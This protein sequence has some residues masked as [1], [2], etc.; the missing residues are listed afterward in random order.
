MR[1]ATC[2]ALLEPFH[3]E[4]IALALDDGSADV[5]CPFDSDSLNTS[6]ATSSLADERTSLRL[7]SF[8]P[9]IATAIS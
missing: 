1:S 4:S 7:L 3:C 2:W 5:K 6:T 8:V 9:E